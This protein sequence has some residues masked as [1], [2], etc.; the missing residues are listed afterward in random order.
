MNQKVSKTFA[1]VILTAI[2][3][4]QAQGRDSEC[5][6]CKEKSQFVRGCDVF[7]APTAEILEPD[8]E[9]L[10]RSRVS[11]AARLGLFRAEQ[12]KTQN[13]LARHARRPVAIALGEAQQARTRRVVL[14]D[15][16][17]VAGMN[18][19]VRE[20]LSG[21]ERGYVF[22]NADSDKQRDF[23]KS[24]PGIG[25]SVRPVATAGDI[26]Q[27]S[28]AMRMRL[29]ADQ[30]ASLV[31]RFEIEVVPSV[32]RLVFDGKTVGA[33]VEE[34]PVSPDDEA[35]ASAAWAGLTEPAAAHR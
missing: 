27:A 1:A 9:E 14:L 26:A 7:V 33:L 18:A 17:T 15:E 29:F 32:V 20:V 31:R 10:L 3:T 21:F 24:L 4:A 22:F 5:V 12:M 28:R 35:T 23:V 6:D 19:S 30:G 34:V 13:A 11:Q 8:W 2:V 25:S 16:K